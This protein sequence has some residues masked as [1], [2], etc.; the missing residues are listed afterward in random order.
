VGLEVGG[1]GITVVIPSLPSRAPMLDRA[2]ASV[3]AQ[4]LLPDEVIVEFDDEGLGAAAIRQRGLERVETEWVAFLDDDDE[5]RPH[6]LEYLM[7]YAVA[8]DADYVF[9]W[10]EV[11][12]GVDPRPSEFGQPWD[13]ENPRQTTITTLVRTALA[14][15]VGG[16]VD[17]A[18]DADLTSPDRHYAGEDWRFTKRVNDAGAKIVHVP[19]KTWIW[20]H[21]GRN[22][23]GLPQ[24]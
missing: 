21:H 10:Y 3:K 20:H 12:G 17:A 23:S 11:V 19:A 8:Q 15:S 16:F 7:S 18:E 22:T 4:T 24:R 5:M 14:R 9:S 6:H 2:L 13:A 1:S